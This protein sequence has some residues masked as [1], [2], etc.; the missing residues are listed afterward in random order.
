M[1]EL[2]TELYPHQKQAVDKLLHVKV[3]ALYMEM[4]T[5]KTRTALEL[6]YRR[7][8]DGK[9]NHILWLCPCTARENIRRDII[10]H[11]RIDSS[12][13]TIRGIESLSSSRKLN[14]ELLNLVMMKDVYLVVDE[15]NLI[16]NPFAIRSKNITRLADFC[17]YKLILNGTPISRT[18]ADLFGQWYVL[19]WRI[20]GYQSFY[21][22]AANHLELDEKTHRVIRALNTEYLSRKIEPYTV[23]IRK[24][25]CLT[26]PSK[27]ECTFY[28]VMTDSQRQHYESVL[29]EFL[30]LEALR[31]EYDTSAIYRTLTAAQ[32]VA[33]G[34]RITSPAYRSIKHKP[35]F[36]GPTE[37]PR[38][39]ALLYVLEDFREEKVII[40]CHYQHEIEDIS[41]VL[42]N[43]GKKFVQYHGGM[44]Q[45]DR[46]SS[47]I[48]FEGDVNIFLANKSCAGYSLNLQF[49]HNIVYYDNDWD[50]ATR[51]QSEDRCHRIGQTKIVDIVNICAACCIDERILKCLSNKENLSDCFKAELTRAHT[52]GLKAWLSG[53]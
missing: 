8:T 3:G 53:A 39:Q 26:L 32:E 21:S 16:K 22:F 18:E 50:W 46:D 35:F 12:E 41:S 28:F 1:M 29:D 17:Q 36:E 43:A 42:S 33:S 34:R 23:Q 19:D 47:V 10:K 6:I 24:A 52:E 9:I 15:S 49:C 40:Y 48:A 2:L 51:A 7:Y 31:S 13:I 37:N 4:G 38:I 20:L 30:S 27:R 45:R 25:E 5:G 44:N 11:A 14:S